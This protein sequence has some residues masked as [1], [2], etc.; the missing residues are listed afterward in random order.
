MRR[1]PREVFTNRYSRSAVN[2]RWPNFLGE[3]PEEIRSLAEE[4]QGENLSLGDVGVRLPVLPRLPL[5]LVLWRG[6]AEFPAEGKVLFDSSVS[7]YLPVEDIVVMAETVVW[8]L[9]KKKSHSPQRAQ[10]TQR[11]EI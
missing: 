2:R 1:S 9:I 5:A 11:K 7:G 10:S 6:D 3:E 4:W 8:K